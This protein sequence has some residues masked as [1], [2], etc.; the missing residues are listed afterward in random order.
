[1]NCQVSSDGNPNIIGE[2][3]Y[4]FKIPLI[5]VTINPVQSDDEDYYNVVNTGLGP[6]WYFKQ[7]SSFV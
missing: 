7:W 1:M 6:N 5:D 2:Q 4:V 3:D